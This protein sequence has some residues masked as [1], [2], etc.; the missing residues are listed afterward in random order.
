MYNCWE[1]QRVAE[2]LETISVLWSHQDMNNDRMWH[3]YGHSR[4]I[5]SFMFPLQCCKI[6]PIFRILKEEEDQIR[7]GICRAQQR[8]FG[9]HLHCIMPSRSPWRDIQTGKFSSYNLHHQRCLTKL[10]NPRCLTT[11]VQSTRILAHACIAIT[12][13]VYNGSSL[14]TLGF[15]MLCTTQL[16][17]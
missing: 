6:L 1:I 7:T 13:Y 12:L 3:I 11:R 10:P 17:L 16:V 4:T 8:D 2:P 15:Q 5:T 14:K 9:E